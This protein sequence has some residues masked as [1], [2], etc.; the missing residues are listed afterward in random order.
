MMKI[1]FIAKLHECYMTLAYIK[2]TVSLTKDTRR[3]FLC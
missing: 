1:K 2:A 3:Y